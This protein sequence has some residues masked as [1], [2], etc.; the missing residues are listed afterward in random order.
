MEYV[1][2]PKALYLRGFED[3]DAWVMV[4]TRDEEAV[5]RAEGY[6][7]LS[8]VG[9]PDAPKRRGRPAGARAE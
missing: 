9:E 2:F 4:H 7:H 5:K 1:E 8:E 6:K 3:L